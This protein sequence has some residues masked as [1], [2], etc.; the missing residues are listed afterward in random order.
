M[1]SI[2]TSL[3]INGTLNINGVYEFPIVDGTANQILATDGSGSLTW[4]DLNN[5]FLSESGV[6]RSTNN[7]DDF[8]IGAD[9]LNYGG[10]GDE[11]KMFFDQSLGALR[12]GRIQNTNWDNT[13]LGGYSFAAGTNTIASGNNS[14]AFGYQTVASGTH[15]LAGGNQSEATGNLSFAFGKEVVAPSYGEMAIGLYNTT[16][17]PNDSIDFDAND[18]LFVIGNGTS[19]SNR[20]DA[21]I[22]YKDGS[23]WMQG[24][25][26]VNST[27]YTSDIRLKHH[28]RPSQYGLNDILNIEVKDYQF[29]KDAT[30][31]L[32]TGFL[33]QQLHTVF[34][35]AVKEGGD[36]E[37]T[38]PWTV[39][40]ASLTPLLVKGMQEQ[41]AVIDNQSRKISD[42]EEQVSEIKQLKQQNAEIKAMLQQIQAQLGNQ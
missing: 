7:T 13:N 25:L 24:D 5:V 33:A 35:H 22:V 32:H 12:A 11:Y 4:S 14:V 21:M 1:N 41:Q 17:T 40:Y 18:R 26:T 10:S 8:V 20:S 19:N 27:S 30:N 36:D 2:A 9:S 28:I 3:Q 42:L 31:H 23:V 16:Y 37:T 39:D 38:N 34:P 29:K 15:S 6:T